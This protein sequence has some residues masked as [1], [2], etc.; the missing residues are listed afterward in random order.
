[1]AAI[2]RRWGRAAVLGVALEIAH[3]PADGAQEAVIEGVVGAFEEQRRLAEEGDQP[4]RDD[5]RLAGQAAVAVRRRDELVDEGAGIGLG[6]RGA[7]G[8]Q[9][10]EPAEAVERLAPGAARRRE[11]EGRAAAG[12]ECA[13]GKDEEAGID[14]ARD[15]RIRRAQVLRG[16]ERAGSGAGVPRRK[17]ARPR[18]AFPRT[19][20]PAS[21]RAS[22]YR[23][24]RSGP[25]STR[26]S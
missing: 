6:E 22:R 17:D 24:Q 16:E 7:G 26:Y 14:V 20:R 2:S 3:E 4:P 11:I 9:M 8:A 10:P 23:R 1:M 15:G 5:L 12:R 13:P 18:E 19:A 21:R 25:R